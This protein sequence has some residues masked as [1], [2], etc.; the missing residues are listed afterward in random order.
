[1]TLHIVTPPIGQSPTPDAYR[2][3]CDALAAKKR[4][5]DDLRERFA[6]LAAVEEYIGESC[7]NAAHNIRSV[8]A[9]DDPRPDAVEWGLEFRNTAARP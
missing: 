8:L 2:A 9:G 4:E 6:A 7:G 3:A 5:L 1:M